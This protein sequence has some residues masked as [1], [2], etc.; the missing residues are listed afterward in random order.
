MGVLFGLAMDYQVFLVSRMREEH[1]HGA[2]PTEAVRLGF[3][4]GARVVLAAALIMISVF[5]SFVFSGSAQISPIAFALA[6]GILFDALV[7]RMT[8]IPAA[9]TLLGKSA[10]WLPRWLD[11]IIPNVDIEGA[12]LERAGSHAAAAPVDEVPAGAHLSPDATHGT[13]A[14]PATDQPG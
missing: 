5:S 2:A 7:V 13:H 1:V 14:A 4:H 6:I 12:A 11:R 9:M 3:A 8:M 10:W